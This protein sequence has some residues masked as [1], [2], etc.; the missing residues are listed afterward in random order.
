MVIT[1]VYCSICR[2]QKDREIELVLKRFW[3]KNFVFK[4]ES[5]LLRKGA[6]DDGRN[7]F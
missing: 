2:F 7:N 3:S 4:V 5:D 6:T 1:N